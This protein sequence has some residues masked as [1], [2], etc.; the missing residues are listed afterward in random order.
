M[1]LLAGGTAGQTA[2]YPPGARERYESR[3]FLGY[4]CEDD[5]ER[6]KA[7]FAWAERHRV[8]GLARC[9][10]LMRVEAE[11][12]RVFIEWRLAPE[13]AGDRWA[14]ENEI[15]DPGLCDGAGERFRVGCLRYLPMEQPTNT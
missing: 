11:G 12:C 9:A 10:Q 2:G 13:A 1:L 14:R 7:G 3:T 6:H 15:A 5:C 8:R 4:A